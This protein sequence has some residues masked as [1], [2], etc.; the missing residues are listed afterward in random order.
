MQDYKVFLIAAALVISVFMVIGS[1]SS[2]V[3]ANPPGFLDDTYS[4]GFITGHTEN[5]TGAIEWI[6]TG[7]W[8]SSLTNDTDTDTNQSPHAFNAAIEMIKSDGT[9]R[10]THTLADFI[11]QSKSA[12]DSNS[13]LYNGTSTISLREGPAVNVTT[14]LQKSNNNNVF[15]LKIDPESVDYHFGELPIYG[16]RVNR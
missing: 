16:I 4:F 8:R 14:T 1:S 15:E 7:N 12:L 5:E 11:V 6:I 10:H 9:A 3:S 2:F 13:T